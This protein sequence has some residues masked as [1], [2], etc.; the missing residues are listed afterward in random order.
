MKQA[1]DALRIYQE[2]VDAGAPA[3]VI[4]QYKSEAEELFQ[5]VSDYY[6]RSMGRPS[7]TLH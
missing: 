4:Q 2:A 6:Q 5:A 1:L 7:G 3:N